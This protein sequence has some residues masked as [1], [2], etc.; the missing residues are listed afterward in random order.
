MSLD[1]L[2]NSTLW[3]TQ[4]HTFTIMSARTHGNTGPAWGKD[5]PLSAECRPRTLGDGTRSELSSR[6]LMPHTVLIEFDVYASGAFLRQRVLK[7]IV[8]SSAPMGAAVLSTVPLLEDEFQTCPFLL[9][10]RS[11]SIPSLLSPVLICLSYIPVHC[12]SCFA[13]L[14]LFSPWAHPL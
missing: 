4:S 6:S 11:P 3:T 12:L 9:N 7:H 14:S 10:L 1:P 2:F 13:W 5:G 8:K